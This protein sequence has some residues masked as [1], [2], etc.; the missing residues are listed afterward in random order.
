MTDPYVQKCIR[1]EELFRSKTLH[2]N[3]LC[4]IVK[5]NVHVRSAEAL[6]AT[7][8]LSLLALQNA[9]SI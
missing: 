5:N 3:V 4:A 8:Y 1:I 2:N 9:R 6:R 7:G